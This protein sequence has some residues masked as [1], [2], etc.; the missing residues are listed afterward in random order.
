MLRT[1]KRS[2]APRKMDTLVDACDHLCQRAV[3]LSTPRTAPRAN[4]TLTSDDKGAHALD[5]VQG[6]CVTIPGYTSTDNGHA[7]RTLWRRW[8]LVTVSPSRPG[9]TRQLPDVMDI[10]RDGNSGRITAT[11]AAT[12]WNGRILV[13]RH[14]HG[15]RSAIDASFTTIYCI[16]MATTAVL[17]RAPQLILG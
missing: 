14:L 5:Q 6:G 2:A 13:V 4:R 16:K 9:R 12:K 3:I 11:T 17:V 15:L 7:E 10:R 1:R 8:E